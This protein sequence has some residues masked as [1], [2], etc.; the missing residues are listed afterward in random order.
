LLGGYIDAV[1]L[2]AHAYEGTSFKTLYMGGGTPSLLGV[3]GLEKLINGLSGIFNFLQLVEATI[4]VNPDSVTEEFLVTA[5][6]LGI[7]RLSIGV[8]SLNDS[9]LGKAGR[10]HTA[11]QAIRAVKMASESNFNNIS[12][13][14]IIGLPG[15]TWS[16]LENTLSTLINLG[17][18]HISAYCLSIEEGTK[19]ADCPP[20][21]LPD[22]DYQADLF[23][24]TR[25]YLK[26]NGFVHY[27]ISNFAL[28]GKE[29]L[30]N[31]NYWRGGEY[32]G[33]GPAA[34][35]HIKGKRYKNM[36][37]LEKY[38]ANPPDIK[39]EEE[40]LETKSK[41]SEEAMLRLRLLSE[42][43][44]VD[45]LVSKYGRDNAGDLI[46]RLDRLVE[47]NLLSKDG[48]KYL[49]PLSEVITSNRVFTRVIN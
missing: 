31:L 17:I 42:G 37:N 9:E 11:E 15:Q 38:L 45:N 39:I 20:G 3:I 49:L 27:E 36:A 22:D 46:C 1:L 34:A 21:D 30:H 26:E 12:A 2:E 23:E 4:E 6:S 40:M 5:K 43:L 29:C 18:V 41:M 47:E 48:N 33:L 14:I 25:L 35:S 19:F 44:A 7:N 32:V 16:S 28:E 13:D 24:Q 8:Q 10:I